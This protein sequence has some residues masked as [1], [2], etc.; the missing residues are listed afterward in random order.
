MLVVGAFSGLGAAVCRA[1]SERFDVAVAD[2]KLEGDEHVDL[3]D[4]DSIRALA[5]ICAKRRSIDVLVL[6]AG[7]VDPHQVP[8]A[9][10]TEALPRMAWVNF[11]GN[12]VLVQELE[13]R[14]CKPGKIVV[15][16]SGAYARGRHADAGPEGF[17][18][19]SWGLTG[20]MGAYSQS[21]FVLTAWAAWLRRVRGQVEI[22]NPGPMRTS[23]GDAGVPSVL[24]PSYAFLREVLFPSPADAA[25]AVLRCCYGQQPDDGYTHIRVPAT[26]NGEVCSEDCQKWVLKRISEALG[27]L[28]YAFPDD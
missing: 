10:D 3:C 15:V 25:Q 7:V 4:V 1:A 14:G 12:A 6:C 9:G 28:G 17:F 27:R 21:K 19:R 23:I 22:I 5:A 16:S 26:L 18:P 2:V 13:R 11:L 8:L 20:A 24:W